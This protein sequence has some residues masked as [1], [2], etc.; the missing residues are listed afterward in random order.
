MFVPYFGVVLSI[1][2]SQLGL[3][4]DVG[5]RWA[6][7]DPRDVRQ[8]IRIAHTCTPALPLFK[9]VLLI[10]LHCIPGQMHAA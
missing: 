2:L 1:W 8:E 3:R 6:R 5:S 4:A 10:C 7:L 9:H